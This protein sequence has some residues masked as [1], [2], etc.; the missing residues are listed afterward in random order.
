MGLV[1]ASVA[2]LSTECLLLLKAPLQ[3][4]NRAKGRT[5]LRQ[6]LRPPHAKLTEL[7]P[8]LQ[9]LTSRSLRVTT[10]KTSAF[11][12]VDDM[13][14]EDVIPDL[15]EAS[16]RNLHQDFGGI[17]VLYES[18]TISRSLNIQAFRREELIDKDALLDD[19]RTRELQPALAGLLKERIR[20]TFPLEP[21]NVAH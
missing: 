8:L 7:L 15:A 6:I 14:M 3:S 16:V 18:I 13:L 20:D 2:G 19:N 10:R 1:R 5:L 21:L 12:V 11:H 17:R 4:C 9:V